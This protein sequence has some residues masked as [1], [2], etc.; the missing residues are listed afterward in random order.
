MANFVNDA[1]ARHVAWAERDVATA[2]RE[3]EQASASER[4]R[5]E[6]AFSKATQRLAMWVL[7]P[8]PLRA[9]IAD[10]EDF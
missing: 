7:L 1:H 9:L 10:E 5:A 3:L 2:L 4:T 6:A 8:A